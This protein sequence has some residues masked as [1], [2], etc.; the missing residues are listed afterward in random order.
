MVSPAYEQLQQVRGYYS[1]PRTLDVDRYTIDGTETDAVVAVREMD[2]AGVEGKQTFE[3]APNGSK[4]PLGDS[5]L[6]PA[7]N[8]VS[9]QLSLDS[10]I[11]WAAQRRIA[12]S[13]RLHRRRP[14]TS[15]SSCRSSAAR[16]R[17]R[18]PGRQ[19]SGR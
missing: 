19:R 11:Q 7:R 8:G 14:G 4:I 9:Y 1:F 5:S 17:S 10:E 6:T 18:P 12:G 3:S 13:M 15:G 2:L 16:R